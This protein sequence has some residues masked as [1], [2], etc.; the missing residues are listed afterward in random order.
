MEKNKEFKPFI[1]ADKVLPEFTITSI[2]LG[3]LLAVIFGAANAYL[4][5]RVGM[6]VSASIPAAVISMGVIRIILRKDSILENNLV[7]TI[8]SAGESVAAGA[9]F[10]LPV[11]FIWMKKWGQAAP[12]L[13]EISII[14][15]CGGILGVLFMIPLRKALI[16][17]EH[18]VLPYPEGTACAEVL[19]AGEE[20]GTKATAVFAGLGISA[21]YKFIGDGLKIFPSRVHYEISSYKG[22]AVGMDVLPAL[23]G[24]GYICGPKISSYMFAGGIIGWIAI[25]PLIS[26]F[27]GSSVFYPATVPISALGSFELWANYL[28]YIG[29]GAVAAGGIISLVKSLPLIVTTFIQA[30][31]DFSGNQSDKKLSRTDKDI[32]MSIVLILIVL[33]I[34]MIGL[35]PA[36]PV[37]FG[38]AI[39]IAL[40]GFF[41]ATVSSRLVGLVGS[42]N[43]PVSGMA[44]ATLLITTMILKATGNIGQK[45]M[46]SAIAIGSVICII[47]A[48]AGD[49]S[50][51]LK[52]GYI[53]GSTPYKQ[54][55]GELIG[56]TI[57]ALTIGGVLY[58]LNSAWGYGSAE[59]PAPQA[60]LMKMVVEGVMNGN[61]P[62]N[63]VFIGVGIAVA[64]EILGIPVLPF[65][66]GLYLPIHLSS[67]IMVGGIVRLYFEKKKKISKE[68][69]KDA[70]DRG[71]LYT[72]GL[73]A[74]EGLVGILLAILAIININGKS[75]GKI[76]DLSSKISLG[77]IG[78]L[79]AFLILVLTLFKFSIWNKDKKQA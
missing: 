29:A 56:V 53:V 31:K 36:V 78:A 75:I 60:T 57:S 76:I 28:K 4:G 14:A 65:A 6:T 33:T 7:Q 16:V 39:L 79:I 24:V 51:D 23:I 42:S 15:L 70:I 50:Q 77:N 32:P 12:S 26:L 2:L 3:I 49:T 63:L 22:S 43:N 45:G 18:G 8:G 55:I 38:G 52:T 34:I 35:V 62:W 61:L 40:F 17:K 25:L 20:G 9:I 59:L 73:I 68:K 64:V 48:I 58:L 74:G 41:F 21:I 44:I 11:I 10:T 13:F 30:I 46:L 37:S 67:A 5:L 27:G 54:Q 19:L 72:S 66:V 1:S 69:R 47:A 71:I